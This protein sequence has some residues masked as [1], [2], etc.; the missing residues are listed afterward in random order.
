MRP[1]PPKNPRVERILKILKARRGPI[2]FAFDFD[3]TLVGFREDPA[4]VRLSKAQSALLSRLSREF[5]V[6]IISG[7]SL[8]DLKARF[9]GLPSVHLAGNH[10]FEIEARGGKSLGDGKPEWSKA[11]RGWTRT[12]SRAIGSDPD[13]RGVLIED[14]HYSLSAHFRGVRSPARTEAALLRWAARLKPAPRIVRGVLVLNLVPADAHHKGDALRKLLR[15]SGCPSAFFAGDDVTDEDV[16]RLRSR[17]VVGVKIGN[18]PS[19]TAARYRLGSRSELSELLR[20]FLRE[21]TRDRS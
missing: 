3:G 5:P 6:A 13:L 21:V 14:K 4:E 2:L 19:R 20:R 10:G 9:R 1:R 11:M 8:R 16:F 15:L 7:R 12:L 17:N 18:R